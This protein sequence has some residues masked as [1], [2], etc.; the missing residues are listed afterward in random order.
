MARAPG[1]WLRCRTPQLSDG[2]VRQRL[3][4]DLQIDGRVIVSLDD[5][6]LLMRKILGLIDQFKQGTKA[7]AEGLE[8]H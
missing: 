2:A 4:D 8:S 3:V 7:C 5:L 1:I 6:S